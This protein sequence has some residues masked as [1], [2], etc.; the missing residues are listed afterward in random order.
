MAISVGRPNNRALKICTPH[1]AFSRFLT[2]SMHQFCLHCI[3]IRY[4][5]KCTAQSK[6][7]DRLSVKSTAVDAC[8]KI[9]K[10]GSLQDNHQTMVEFDSTSGTP[11][12]INLHYKRMVKSSPVTGKNFIWLNHKGMYVNQLAIQVNSAWPSLHCRCIKCY[13]KLTGMTG[14]RRC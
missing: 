14:K 4:N 6:L 12:S 5:N 9:I 8:M 13:Q 1:H 2:S 7:A 10:K 11:V 3:I